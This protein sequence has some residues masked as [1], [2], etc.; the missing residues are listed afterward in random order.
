VDAT[1]VPAL[2]LSALAA[3]QQQGVSAVVALPVLGVVE[4]SES[5]IAHPPPQASRY[6][7]SLFRQPL[8]ISFLS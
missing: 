1:T 4:V 3:P 5:G 7:G 2:A 8:F 6:S